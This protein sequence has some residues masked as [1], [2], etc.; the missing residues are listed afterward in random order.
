MA[1]NELAQAHRVL[2]TGAYISFRDINTI[3]LVLFAAGCG[4]RSSDLGL[5]P[6]NRTLPTVCAPGAQ[7]EF[8]PAMG[9]D[10]PE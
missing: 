9:L 10:R 7:G 3:G 8:D 6:R 2:A 5:K 1:F 4:E